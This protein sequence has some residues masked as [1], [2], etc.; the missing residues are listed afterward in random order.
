MVYSWVGDMG[1]ARASA[2]VFQRQ[3]A[4]DEVSRYANLGRYLVDHH[5]DVIIYQS[6]ADELI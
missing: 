4:G 1:Y 5:V 6:M 3:N 2:N